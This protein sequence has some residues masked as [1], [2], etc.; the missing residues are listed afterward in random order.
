VGREGT[1]H[2][3]CTLGKLGMCGE[4]DPSLPGLINL[5]FALVL[6]VLARTLTMIWLS[7]LGAVLSK[8]VRTP[9]NEAT[10]CFSRTTRLF[11][12]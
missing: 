3:W 5:S 7:G 12:T 9:T 8:V 6:I 11:V 2:R 4:I 1:R 10:F